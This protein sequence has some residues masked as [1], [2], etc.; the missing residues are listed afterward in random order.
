M[1]IKLNIKII[2]STVL[3]SLLGVATITIL[4]AANEK[5]DKSLCAGYVVKFNRFNG[6]R[7]VV[8]ADV[9][10]ILGENSNPFKGKMVQSFELKKM[11]AELKINQW[12]E[13]ANIYID[14]SN[15]LQIIVKEKQPLA[16]LFFTN[17]NSCYLDSNLKTIP[18]HSEFS[19]RL[20]VFT[21]IQNL[22]TN[23]S[24][25]DSLVLNQIK[26]I[27]IF[28]KKND[29]WMANIDQINFNAEG[30][31]EMIPKIGDYVILFGNATNIEDKFNNLAEFYNQVLQKKGWNV[32]KEINVGFEN[33]IIAIRKDI[34]NVNVD[35]SDSLSNNNKIIPE[36]NKKQIETTKNLI[37]Q[38]L[39]NKQ[40]TILKK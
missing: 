29:F 2:V 24:Q 38:P 32:Y 5:G 31:I 40:N 14:N 37:P 26:D 27:A 15:I 11:E 17:G 16:R 13:N 8:E 39:K 25:K 3:W 33:Q 4:V 20:P 36:T 21:G 12:I 6:S 28:L 22:K 9:L 23:T 10:N 35:T 30:N 18:L 1:K 19:A 7:F 34:G